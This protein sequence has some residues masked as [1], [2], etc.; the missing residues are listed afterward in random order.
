MAARTGDAALAIAILNGAAANTITTLARWSTTAYARAL[1]ESSV[2]TSI[3]R[4]VQ[5]ADPMDEPTDNELATACERAL[6]IPHILKGIICA[7]PA[8]D[9]TKTKR[10]CGHWQK[11]ILRSKK[12]RFARALAPTAYA[13]LSNAERTE[14]L[15]HRGR[16]YEL[17]VGSNL[18]HTDDSCV[19]CLPFY[20][21]E[22]LRLHPLLRYSSERPHASFTVAEWTR[23][24]PDA[25]MGFRANCINYL[26]RYL[27][28]FVTSP[29]CTALAVKIGVY[30]W[31]TAWPWE[32]VY[33]EG[34][35]QHCM[36]RL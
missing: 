26:D 15:L 21:T 32:A 7:L 25:R 14:I 18:L 20:K 17:S 29:R 31:P 9:I 6:N 30:G 10:V 23:D 12:I 13:D 33:Q 8:T 34:Y 35:N 2:C 4:L 24:A 3:L 16:A 19:S 1:A 28:E 22:E 5:S 27:D 11:T 36:V